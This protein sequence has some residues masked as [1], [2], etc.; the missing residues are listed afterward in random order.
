MG[1]L[2]AGWLPGCVSS[3]GTEELEQGSLPHRVGDGERFGG[4]REERQQS[5][6]GR[7][8]RGEAHVVQ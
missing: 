6:E 7:A 8:R 4:L 2:G 5:G 1:G 3:F